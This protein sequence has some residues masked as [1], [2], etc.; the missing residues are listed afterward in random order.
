MEQFLPIL[1]P[2]GVVVFAILLFLIVFKTMYKVAD[3]DKALI[4]TGGKKPLIK[5]SGGAFVIPVFR[6]YD[7]F[8]LSMLTVTAS[9]DEIMTSTS[10]PIEINWTAQIRPDISSMDNLLKA[11]ISFKE[12]G[13]EAIISDTRMTLMGGVRDV[14]AAMTPEG[15]LKEKAIF[16]SKVK[17]LI[18]DEM[19]NMGMELV[20][21]NIQDINDNNGYYN[22]I[23]ELD[24][25]D[26]RRE[27]E[28]KKAKVDQAIRTQNAESEREA[29]Q[30]ELQSELAIAE[31]TRD[32]RL[33]MAEYK[34]ETDKADADAAVA[35]QLQK[36][37]RA[38]EI[39]QQEGRVE[40]VRQEQANMAAQKEQEVIAT[41]A[42]SEKKKKRIEAEADAN[43]QTI[44]SEA[45]VK[46][47]E[48]EA[49]AVKIQANAQAER[50][51]T[52]GDADAAVTK[53]KGE[54]QADV[55]RQ[56]GLAEAEVARQ[57]GL[58]EAEVIKQQGLAEAEV[59]RQKL[60]AQAE[61]EQA[62]AEARASNDKVNF[63]IEKLKIETEGK[64]Q[65]ATKA[66]QLMGSVGS[67][68]EFVNIGGSQT[69]GSGNVLV[70]TLASIPSLMRTL[71][72]ENEALNGKPFNAELRDLVASV[73]DPAKGILATTVNAP[74]GV[75]TT[76]EDVA[77]KPTLPDNT[78]NS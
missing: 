21:L 65:V 61:G 57:M 70:D 77:E 33:K 38:Q 13:K 54:A 46:V 50:V 24:M 58:A 29:S 12:R 39:A 74:V 5:I 62:L 2:V 51:R 47:A 6:K 59:E 14:V 53:K 11:I 37:I 52:E 17:D 25:Q 40:V 68:A 60:M 19:L 18:K 63:E 26:K 3:V 30:N 15:V 41:R 27:A 69:G 16:A 44:S 66:A 42:E 48:N 76:G 32:N 23:A 55:V 64:V 28:S 22:N 36:T 4:V 1:I 20:S 7:Y 67:K 56:K 49:S 34:A 43:V 31:K 72:A 35:G 75:S 10:V 73:L 45:K 78:D 8:D 9:N 71:N